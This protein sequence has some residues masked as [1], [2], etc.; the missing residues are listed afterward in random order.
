MRMPARILPAAA[1]ASLAMLTAAAV[2]RAETCTLE[3]KRVDPQN[4]QGF[5][6]VLRGANPQTIFVQMAKGGA[7]VGNRE[8]MAAFKGIVKKEPKY[9][10]ENPFRG[11]VTLGSQQYAFVLDAVPQ[12]SK[13][14]NS[15]VEKAKKKET[16][17]KLVV[18]VFNRLYFDLNHNG[19][20]TDDKPIDAE[21]PIGPRPWGRSSASLESIL[22][23]TR[24][25]PNW[26][27]PFSWKDGATLRPV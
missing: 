3:L 4:P 18:T 9:C 27:I 6:Y 25:E 20:L 14:E 24:K 19:D 22:P 15:D 23:L 8:T 21:S 5:D 2:V 7:P 11:T 16:K 10:S 12:A 26:T 13:G 17:S 1:I